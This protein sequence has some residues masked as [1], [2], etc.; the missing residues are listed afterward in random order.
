MKLQLKTIAAAVALAV[1]AGSAAAAVPVTSTATGSE[2][3]FYAFDDATKTSYVQDL[4]QT[5]SSFLPTSAAAGA[6]FSA[7]I[8]SNTAWASY[9]ASVAGDF[10]NTYWGVVAGKSISPKGLLTTVRAG[11]SGITTSSSGTVQGG[12]TTSLN[13]LMNGLNTATSSL[14]SGY[15]TANGGT[16]ADNI[17]NNYGSGH[18]IAGKL[19]PDFHT[20]NLIGTSSTFEYLNLGG[21]VATNVYANAYGNSTFSFDGTTLAYTVAAVPEPSSYAMMLGG[22]ML[23]GGIAARRRKSGK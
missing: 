16:A 23:V 20:D 4:G 9:I 3:L 5:Y 2:L 21:S 1:V 6:N 19:G 7:S 15:F 17:V 14:A 13:G 22:L 12:V 18:N 10:S 8:S 11:D